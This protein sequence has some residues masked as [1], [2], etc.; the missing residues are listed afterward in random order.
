MFYSLI[1]T[2][3]L[4]VA[5]PMFRL[6]VEGRERFPD[7]GPAILVALHCSWLDP[8]CVAV[9]IARPVNF[10][11][12]ETLYRTPWAWWF[13][14]LLR[15]IPISSRAAVG[16]LRRALRRLQ[17]GE[18]VGVFPEGRVVAE[19][20][21]ARIHAGA[22]L[23]AVH[24]GAPVIPLAIEGSM[25]AWPR[26]R[27]QPVSAQIRS[28][29]GTPIPPPRERGPGPVEEMARRIERALRGGASE[30]RAL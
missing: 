30:A 14:R 15:T 29:V 9:A 22:A 24:A 1:R 4:I 28:R 6:R 20:Q 25:Q 27:R 13:Y 18:V 21:H 3:F 26:G 16:P 19:G 23:L 17:R 11:V 12:M 5:A 7:H 2:L 10:L 8:F